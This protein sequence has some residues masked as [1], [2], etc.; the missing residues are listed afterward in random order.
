M[1]VKDIFVANIKKGEGKVIVKGQ[2]QRMCSAAGP[3]L[4]LGSERG[5]VQGRHF[6]GYR[7]SQ[8]SSSV[9]DSH[10]DRQVNRPGKVL[11][12]RKN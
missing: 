9:S 8:G 3:V 5:L 10:D 6:M 1:A 2:P 7:Q 4:R 12:I 11:N